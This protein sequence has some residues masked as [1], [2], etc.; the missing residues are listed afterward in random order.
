MIKTALKGQKEPRKITEENSGCVRPERV[1][2][3]FNSLIAI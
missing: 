3:W 1:N 2:K